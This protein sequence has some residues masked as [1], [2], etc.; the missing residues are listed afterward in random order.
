MPMIASCCDFW[1]TSPISY[2]C[3]HGRSFAAECGS[4]DRPITHCQGS[5]RNSSAASRSPTPPPRWS[6]AIREAIKAAGAG[7][8]YLPP[9]R[10]DLN[11]IEQVFAKLKALLR[12]AGATTKEALWTTLGTLL[13][14]FGPSEC[15][16]DLTNSGYECK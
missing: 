13:D 10:P 11:P 2:R 9:Y 7:V 6:N 3:P 15:R 16:N 14:A 8:L 5:R 4:F 1:R 12:K